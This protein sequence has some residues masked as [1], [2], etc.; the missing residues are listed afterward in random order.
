MQIEL[1][2]IPA[3]QT[4]LPVVGHASPVHLDA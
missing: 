1:V 2:P 4:P 3:D